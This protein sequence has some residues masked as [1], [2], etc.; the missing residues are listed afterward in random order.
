MKLLWEG[1][2]R[3]GSGHSFDDLI[4]P[5]VVSSSVNEPPTL[6]HLQNDS[7]MSHISDRPTP[8]LR[9]LWTK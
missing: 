9:L 5:T 8:L 6:V 2:C 7:T 3:A 1:M 4:T